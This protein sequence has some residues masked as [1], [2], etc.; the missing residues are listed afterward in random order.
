MLPGTFVIAASMT[1]VFILSASA[2]EK[3]VGTYGGARASLAFKIPAAT[4][5]SML[6][7]GWLASPF[8]AG[9]SKGANLVVTFMDWLVALYPDG[10]ASLGAAGTAAVV[11]SKSS[12]P[13][14]RGAL[15][16]P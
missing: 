8:S 7:R 2:Q 5:Q 6:L 11:L 1:L 13:R 12:A 3:L 15:A 14:C 16:C 9:P 4:A 10:L